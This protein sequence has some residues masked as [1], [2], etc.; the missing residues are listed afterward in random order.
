M[1]TI[2]INNNFFKKWKREKIEK[3]EV[4]TKEKRKKKE[5]SKEDHPPRRAKNMFCL[6][7]SFE[8][9][10]AIEAKKKSDFE[11][12]RKKKKGKKKEKG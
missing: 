11:L 12:L 6:Q 8:N 5:G 3:K 1:S 4:K 7:L 9:R 2:K 10:E